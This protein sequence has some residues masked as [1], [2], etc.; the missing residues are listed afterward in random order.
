MTFLLLFL[1]FLRLLS[2]K[3]AHTKRTETEYQENSM[4][5]FHAMAAATETVKIVA[6]IDEVH[7]ASAKKMTP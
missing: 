2:S 3:Q 1:Y 6:H 5:D 4:A 7:P